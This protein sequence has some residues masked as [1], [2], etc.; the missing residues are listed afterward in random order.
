M[1]VSKTKF[2]KKIFSRL[3]SHDLYWESKTYKLKRSIGIIRVR[4]FTCLPD[5]PDTKNIPLFVCLTFSFRHERLSGKVRILAAQNWKESFTHIEH[6]AEAV[7][8]E[9]LVN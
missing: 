7:G 9:G 2:E 6:R 8:Q 5:N 3:L 1:H 4:V